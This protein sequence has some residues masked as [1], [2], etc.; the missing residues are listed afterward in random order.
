MSA[1]LEIELTDEQFE[2]ASS[3]ESHP[4]FVGGYGSGKS[5][6]AICRIIALKLHYPNLNVA[7]YLPTYD[8]IS[9]I[10]FPR[11]SEMLALMEI[12]HVLN[13]SEKTITV[14]KGQIIFRTMDNPERIIGYEVADSCVD[15]L[16]TLP[17][18]KAR[19][20]WNKIVARNRQKKLDGEANTIGVATTPEGYRFVYDM[21]VKNKKDGYQVIRAST[22]S[23]SKNLPD[24]Y[25]DSLKAIYPEALL[26]AYLEGHFCN[27]T[28]GTV[29]RDYDR[30]RCDSKEYIKPLEPLFI[31]QDFNVGEMASAIFVRRP[32]GL[33]A[34]KEI[35]GVY[36]TPELV[37]ILHER[38]QAPDD[39]HPIYMYPDASGGSR[40]TVDAS[41]TDISL[42][43]LAGF[44]I[45][46]DKKNPAVKDRIISTN[47]AFAK[48][49]VKVNAMNCPQT[50]ATLEQQAY[51]KNGEPDK[52][53]GLDHLNDAFSYCVSYE[54]PI[55]KLS[56]TSR[57]AY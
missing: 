24:G 3:Q 51:G 43:S 2:F 53:G 54:Y 37:K 4:L 20:V 29:Y 55:V 7:Y 33:H 56:A 57:S 39:H 31:G 34:V 41:K 8:L 26:S 28:S 38:Y 5:H 44:N 40:K 52:A 45:Q 22:E 13:K 48:G 19:S 25:V 36:D 42:L 10:G 14:G 50:A 11:F 16:D 21:W 9:T 32:D 18:E 17:T 47:I 27:L 35:T 23:N 15:E 46:A 12:H 6:A 49:Y 30:H 1:A